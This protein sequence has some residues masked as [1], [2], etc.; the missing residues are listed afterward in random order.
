MSYVV[1]PK[2]LFTQQSGSSFP[3]IL[4]PLGSPKSNVVVQRKVPRSTHSQP[5]RSNSGASSTSQD[6][7]LAGSPRKL[8][9]PPVPLTSPIAE[10]QL[11]AERR[12]PSTPHKCRRL[13][14]SE[15]GGS[16]ASQD[17]GLAGSPRKLPCP[18]IFPM[19]PTKQA[20][21]QRQIRPFLISK[22][23]VATHESSL[24]SASDSSSESCDSPIKP[25][26]PRHVITPRRSRKNTPRLGRGVSK[27]LSPLNKKLGLISLSGSSE[28]DVLPEYDGTCRLS[29]GS[30]QQS[31]ATS[32]SSEA[33]APQVLP[34]LPQGDS[35]PQDLL[36]QG[37]PIHPYR[38]SSS[39]E[40]PWTIPEDSPAE[41]PQDSPDEIT[42]PDSPNQITLLDSPCSDIRLE[43]SPQKHPQPPVR[44]ATSSTPPRPSTPLSDEYQLSI[45]TPAPE[46][47]EP[48]FP[49][50]FSHT[51]KPM[52]STVAHELP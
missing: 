44:T 41:I 25:C 30:S 7:E 50:N 17:I 11:V 8:P 31:P 46:E 16:S 34:P 27:D 40:S 19:S 45:G 21:A 28:A 4:D 49:D 1:L 36:V 48:E 12:L 47:Q 13:Q 37:D 35:T 22:R 33:S 14:R 43:G 9:H 39:P 23:D 6:I 42:F 32:T 51:G 26:H 38:A 3:H 10:Q 18:P 52:A 15:S 2:K 20:I 5:R 29:N 24:S